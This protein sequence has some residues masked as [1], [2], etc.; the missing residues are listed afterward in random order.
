MTVSQ[1]QATISLPRLKHNLY[2]IK[3]QLN[4]E[5]KVM[6][7]VKANAYSH[8]LINISSYLENQKIDYFGVA[9]F[10]EALELRQNHINTPILVLSPVSNTL[11]DQAIIHHIDLTISSLEQVKVLQQITKKLN[12]PASLHLKI[13]TGMNR[14]GALPN[15][16]IPLIKQINQSPLLKLTG[17]FTHFS[18]SESP[19]QRETNSQLK[20]FN[21][22][23]KKIHKNLSSSVL[24]HSANSAATISRK[25]THFNMVRPGLALYGLNPFNPQPNP[26]KLKPILKLE[27][28]VSRTHTALK[29]QT[30]GYSNT[31]TLKE[32]TLVATIP[33]GYGDGLSL[34]PSWPYATINKQI[35]PV[36]GRVS[37]DQ[38]T[39]D[40]NR[41]KPKPKIGQPITLISW[42][43]RH[44]SSVDK[45]ALELNT[46]NYHI[47]TALSAR[48]ERTY[49]K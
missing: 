11:I 28:P 12:L 49:L 33:A 5:T 43:H 37:M 25:D 42:C 17:V 13:D 19:C 7:I 9:R 44:P 41:I 23:L 24:I 35:A 18:S 47:V 3:S 31:H 16:V 22:S 27:A 34:F 20:I 36:I 39:L 8:G 29:G 30:I 46:I 40:I 2:T 10:D 26:I 21:Q 1:I 45:L 38:I 15:K 48:I 14:S 4:P 32:D 6:A